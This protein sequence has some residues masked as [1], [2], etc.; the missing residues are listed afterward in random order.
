MKRFLIFLFAAW[1]LLSARANDFLSELPQNSV[2][3]AGYSSTDSIKARL[4]SLPLCPI[5]GL[6]QMGGD[7]ALFVVERAEWSTAHAPAHLKLVMVRSPWRSIRP[8]TVFGHAVVTAKP[9]VYEARIYS[10]NAQ[11][12]GLALPRKFT[13]TVDADGGILT[14]KPF[15]LPFRINIFR[16]LPYMYRRVI[17]PQQSR[18]DGLDGAVRVFPVSAAHPLTPVYL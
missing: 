7:G 4:A 5:E 6:W 10:E 16:L 11:R 18:P 1:T 9:G 14:F 17:T 3:S 12:S 2:L 8:G 13:L 15:K